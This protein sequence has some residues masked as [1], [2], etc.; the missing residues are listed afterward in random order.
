MTHDQAK[1]NMVGKWLAKEKNG[2]SSSKEEEV[3]DNSAKGDSNLGSGSGNPS[4]KEDRR[5]EESTQMDV[6]MVFMIPVEFSALT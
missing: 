6:N 4:R 5:E 1:A 3:E 2:S